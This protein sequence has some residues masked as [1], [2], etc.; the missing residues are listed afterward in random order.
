MKKIF[1][2]LTILLLFINCSNNLTNNQYAQLKKAYKEHNYFRLNYLMSSL[3][4]NDKDTELQLYMAKLHYVFNKPAE[5]NVLI[6]KILKRN[7]RNLNDSVVADLYYMRAN[8]AD[9]LQDYGKAGLDLQVILE[10]Y[11]HVYD[12]SFLE[13]L[14]DDIQIANALNGVPKMTIQQDADVTISL[15]RDM[16]GLLNIPVTLANDSIDFVFD[17]GANISVIVKSLANDYGIKILPGKINVYGFTNKKFESEIGLVDFGIGELKVENAVFLV[18][19]DSL[20][21]FANGAY[22]IRGIVGFPVMNALQELVFENDQYLTIHKE[23]ESSDLKNF[24][25]DNLNPVILVQYENDTLPFHFDTGADHTVFFSAFFNKYKDAITKYGKKSRIT[26]GGAGG[27]IEADAYILDSVMIAAGRQRLLLSS[28][29][30]LTEQ[31]SH[32]HEY[33]YGNF[34]QDFIKKF[35]KMKMNLASMYIVFSD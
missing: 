16:A 5:S 9:R 10:K 11:S 21:S 35:S 25:L 17:T 7:H 20:L 26:I 31:I 13:E 30:I 28:V 22:V 1:T 2:C 15:K 12:S 23:P 32:D 24:A 6:D 8:N 3:K 19:P 14:K 34:G 27:N 18:L 33:F 29:E 4:F